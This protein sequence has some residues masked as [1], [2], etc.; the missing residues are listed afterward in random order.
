M[1]RLAGYLVSFVGKSQ[2]ISRRAKQKWY[3]AGGASSPLPHDCNLRQV[4]HRKRQPSPSTYF[5]LYC[6]HTRA[7][8]LLISTSPAHGRHR[9]PRRIPHRQSSYR[10]PHN[11]CIAYCRHAYG[12]RY[13]AA[14][15]KRGHSQSLINSNPNGGG[16]SLP[17]HVP[18]R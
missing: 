8:A 13:E 11:R 4:L 15:E 5:L 10:M 2:W 9:R 18:R 1:C 12:G 3:A 16:S 17:F 7:C 6:K 14:L